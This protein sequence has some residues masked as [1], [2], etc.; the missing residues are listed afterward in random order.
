MAVAG[1]IERACHWSV[2]S[3]QSGF[4]V[5]RIYQSSNVAITTNNF[6]IFRDQIKIDFWQKS[7]DSISTTQRNDRRH[8]FVCPHLMKI[9]EPLIV[10]S[11]KI[12]ITVIDVFSDFAFQSQFLQPFKSELNIARIEGWTGRRDNADGV[13]F[14]K[15]LCLDYWFQ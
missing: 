8:F 10:C 12:A 7:R 5:D 15:L 13:A 3:D 4:L 9:F 2:K 1:F 11:C 14:S 6:W